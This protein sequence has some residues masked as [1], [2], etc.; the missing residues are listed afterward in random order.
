[1]PPLKRARPRFC[2]GAHVAWTRRFAVFII[3]YEVALAVVN[4]CRDTE[5]FSQPPYGKTFQHH[6][7]YYCTA[8]L[9]FALQDIY[10]FLFYFRRAGQRQ[11]EGE[12]LKQAEWIQVVFHLSMVLELLTA[13]RKEKKHDALK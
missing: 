5:L 8:Y 11:Q 6:F 13:K 3:S 10:I 4:A 9:F 2:F 7:Y 1:M 12:K